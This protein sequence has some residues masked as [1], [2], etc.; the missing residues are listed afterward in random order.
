MSECAHCSLPVETD[1]PDRA[2]GE[3]LCAPCRSLHEE[4]LGIRITPLRYDDLELVMAWRS[5]PEIYRY[6]RQQ[7]GPL[8]WDDHLTWY[9]TRADDR[10]D[11]IIHFDGRRVGGVSID[12]DD[13]V[14]IYLGDVSARGE[15]IAFAA[16]TWLCERFVSRTPLKAEI[17]RENEASRRLFEKC[18]F[19]LKEDEESTDSDWLHYVYDS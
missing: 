10:F 14:G 18:G 4:S 16:L 11:F 15:G 9:E 2:D 12:S 17:H 7:V 6:F 19:V 5:N 3:T 8:R 1:S 13:F